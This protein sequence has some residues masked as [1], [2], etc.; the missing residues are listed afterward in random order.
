VRYLTAP[1]TL[2]WFTSPKVVVFLAER[3]WPVEPLVTS[4]AILLLALVVRLPFFLESDFPLNDGGMFFVMAR[5]I[6]SAHYALPATTSYNGDAIPFA[7]PPL[8]FYLTTALAQALSLPALVVVRYLPLVANL[9][10]TVAF[11]ALARSL[12]GR[13]AAFFAAAA[14]VVVPRSYEWLVM[15]GGLTRSVGLVFALVALAQA[16]AL[17]RQPTRW[18]IG[19]VALAVALTALS[20]LEMGLFV[21]Y[22]FGLLF[23]AY[24]RSWQG[25]RASALVALG[26]VAL[27][28]PWWL[29]VL[30]YHGL[31]PF[32]AASTTA[33]WSGFEHLRSA[34]FEFVF[35]PGQPFFTVLGGLAVLG[36]VG[37]LLRGAW[38]LPAWLPLVFLLTPRSA[39]TE[40]TVPLALLVGVGLGDVVVRGLVHLARQRHP[41]YERL[42]ATA[43]A[44]AAWRL[45]RRA[46]LV[47]AASTVVFGYAVLPSWLPWDFGAF[48]LEAL[49]DAERQSMAWVA[50]ATP[51]ESTFLVLSPKV[52][53]EADYVLEWF[54][55]LAG[56][57]SV[58]TPQ[59]AEWLAAWTHARRT[60]AYNK[61]R[62]EA[63][64]NAAQMQRWLGRMQVPYSHVYVSKQVQGPIDLEPLRQELLGSPG[65][66]VLLDDAGATVL[67]RVGA[68]PV[69]GQVAGEPPI[70]PDCRSFYDE[71]PRVQT[72]FY[73]MHGEQA[74]WAWVA[75]HTRELTQRRRWW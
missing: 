51:P 73:M 18:R 45:E 44:V 57:K 11:V 61:F 22:S 7:Y 69:V 67:A 47:T 72:A 40:G 35:P 13:R 14:F 2:P 66:Q 25:V 15:G 75:E 56:R 26:A 58:L 16:R 37:C 70:A 23:L 64:G 52:S 20:H 19:G 59:G 10:A 46:L 30:H 17:Y 60:C 74:P 1:Q 3:R 71:P 34:L 5:E 39:A 48:A 32:Q 41:L 38:W 68:G 50:A 42:L 6:A 21:V 29:T 9:L 65:Y 8:P 49:P 36:A 53:W 31:A 28:A 43:P 63:L 55:A 27:T 12:L 33:G 54:P 24:G 4:L 62:A